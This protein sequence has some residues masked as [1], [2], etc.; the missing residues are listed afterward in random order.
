[1][2][3]SAPLNIEGVKPSTFPTGL[4]R[5]ILHATIIADGWRVGATVRG[6][7]KFD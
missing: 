2:T 3:A 6:F 1:M 5:L 7:D 4:E